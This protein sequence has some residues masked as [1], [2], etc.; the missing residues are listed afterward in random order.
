MTDGDANK[1]PEETQT[2]TNGEPSKND[3][4]TD[5]K[6]TRTIL[7]TIPLFFKFA[8]V[9]LIKIVTDL[10]VFPLIGL[11]SLAGLAKR[12]FLSAIGKGGSDTAEKTN[13]EA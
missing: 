3:K 2:E 13:G 12:R 1:E 5:E 11:Y 6:R 10:I 4:Q 9:L 8:I 7:L